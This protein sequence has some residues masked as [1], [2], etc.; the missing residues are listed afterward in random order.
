MH[1]NGAKSMSIKHANANVCYRCDNT[2]PGAKNRTKVF[3]LQTFAAVRFVKQDAAVFFLF[4]LVVG[5]SRQ[6]SQEGSRTFA[7]P[8]N[9]YSRYV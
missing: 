3:N 8:E 6:N 7:G 1:A 2:W 4:A 5:D 9:V